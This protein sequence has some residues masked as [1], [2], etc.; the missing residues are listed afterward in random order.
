[1]TSPDETVNPVSPE[2]PGSP[3]SPPFVMP[4]SY[5]TT[6]EVLFGAHSNQQSNTGRPI[7][8][9][10][11][12]FCIMHSTKNMNNLHAVHNRKLCLNFHLSKCFI[13]ETTH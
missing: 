8:V 3:E 13:F 4:S 6:N 1:M 12:R 11:S 2:S 7:T 9:L 5:Q 10:Y